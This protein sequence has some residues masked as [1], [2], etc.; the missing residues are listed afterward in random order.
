[1]DQKL[2]Y[3]LTLLFPSLKKNQAV[4]SDNGSPRLIEIIKFGKIK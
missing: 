2:F 1:M 3:E 4:V